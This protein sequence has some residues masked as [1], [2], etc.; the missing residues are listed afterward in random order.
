MLASA[1][2]SPLANLKK[3]RWG[4]RHNVSSLDSHITEDDANNLPTLLPGPEIAVEIVHG[5]ET[6][7]PLEVGPEATSSSELLTSLQ[8]SS[9]FAAMAISNDNKSSTGSG[10]TVDVA[11]TKEGFASRSQFNNTPVSHLMFARKLILI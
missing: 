9:T 4:P 3:S 7:T 11:G 1:P 5:S 8:R 10:D 6:S 2:T